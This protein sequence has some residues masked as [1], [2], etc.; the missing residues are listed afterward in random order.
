MVS[1]FDSIDKIR[2]AVTERDRQDKIYHQTNMTNCND[3]LMHLYGD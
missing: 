3:T 1:C 2:K